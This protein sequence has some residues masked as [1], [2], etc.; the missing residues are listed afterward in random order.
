MARLA[1]GAVSL[2]IMLLFA[3]ATP[4]AHAGDPEPICRAPPVVEVM[5]RE[6]R[7]RDPYVRVRPQWIVEYPSVT[8]DVVLCSVAAPT[9]RYDAS[10]SAGV[11]LRYTVL[12]GFRVRAVL[13]GYVV[14]FV[15]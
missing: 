13:D 8:P 4:P 1:P 15:R 7:R 12:H 5:A 14:T 6:L 10:R 11:P 9:L 2:L 3:G